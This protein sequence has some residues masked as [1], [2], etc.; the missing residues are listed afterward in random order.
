MLLLGESQKTLRAFQKA[1]GGL[2][3]QGALGG[4]IGGKERPPAM[5]TVEALSEIGDSDLQPS[6]ARRALLHEKRGVRHDGISYY[7]E[8]HDGKG[9]VILS[10]VKPNCNEK[11]EDVMPE[12]EVR[13][14]AT[15]AK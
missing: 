12:K 8:N 14:I 3:I 1:C 4:W 6:S 15:L 10:D 7:R 5:L 9:E 2:I 13:K 11:L